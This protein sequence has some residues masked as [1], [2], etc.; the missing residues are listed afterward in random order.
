MILSYGIFGSTSILLR[1]T[2]NAI[3]PN[4]EDTTITI[5][6]KNKI[7]TKMILLVPHRKSADASMQSMACLRDL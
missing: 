5:K 1:D 7:G 4:H 3:A 2:T 6:T